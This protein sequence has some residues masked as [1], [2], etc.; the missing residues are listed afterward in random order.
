MA[1]ESG[2]NIDDANLYNHPCIRALSKKWKNSAIKLI[3]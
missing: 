2:V 1:A 3:E